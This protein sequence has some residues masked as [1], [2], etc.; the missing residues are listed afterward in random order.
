MATPDAPSRP[1]CPLGVS[2]RTLSALRDGV[3]RHG[4]AARLA[5]HVE[6]CAACRE[7]LS[8]FDDLAAILRS[9]RPPESDERLWR[10]IVTAASSPSPAPRSRFGRPHLPGIGFSRPSWTSLGTL[11]AVL[12]LTVGF[13]A[14]LGH[15][16]PSSPVQQTPTATLARTLTPTAPLALTATP[17]PT[18]TPDLLPA[19]PLTWQPVDLTS[20]QSTKFASDGRS[21]YACDVGN[22][23]Q[24]N[25][26]LNIWHTSDR[27]ADWISARE[28]PADPSYAGCELVVD[29]ADPSVA[30]LAWA[31]RGN[32]G[33]DTGLMTTVDGGITW[34]AV[35][36]QTL[37]QIDQLDSR[38]GVIYAVRETVSGGN[39]L[40]Y[41]LWAS[42]DRM[43]SWRQMDHGLPAYVQGFWL[44]PD[45]VSILL[46]VSSGPTVIPTQFWSSPDGGATWRQLD[47]PVSLPTT[48]RPARVRVFGIH[49]NNIVVRSIQGQFHICVWNVISGTTDTS[50]QDSQPPKV[51]CSSDGGV[52]W[53]AWAAPFPTTRQDIPTDADL[54]GITNEG[55]LL[56][57]GSG[58]LYRIAAIAD[59]DRW[60]P[61]GTPPRL[62][63]IY[64]PSPGAGILWAVGPLA[65][66]PGNPGD[67]PNRI[68]TATY[69]P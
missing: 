25:G 59:A 54:V 8:A 46:V 26:V 38:G 57:S 33:D 52:T 40:E 36:E 45:G 43:R 53:R 44:Q 19:R 22:D 32:N 56:V 4:Q 47:V 64:C 28:I 62:V 34:Q 31:P 58:I 10:A 30:A 6:S 69:A 61:L 5:A 51:T 21:G 39:S 50:I 12:L 67:Q 49:W 1:V 60:Q 35:A 15:H 24:G 20:A 9:E 66:D 42:D 7:R 63:V 13:V 37:T 48:Y 23:A 29:G 65:S 18:A 41:H 17:R 16:L 2:D 3:M 68:F 11:A 14:L 55:A 27:G